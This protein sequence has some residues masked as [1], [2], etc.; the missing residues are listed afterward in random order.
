MVADIGLPDLETRQAILKR[1][2]ISQNK[3]VDDKI[4][5]FIA[6]NIQSSIRELEGALTK[7]IAT[8]ELTHLEITL[9]NAEN[10]LKGI[11]EKKKQT[12]TPEFIIREIAKYYSISIED[13]LGKKRTKEI[14]LSRQIT[15]YFL[16][17]ETGMSFPDIGKK[18]GG[19]DLPV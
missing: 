17:H 9:E 6:T 8:C 14:V 5:E 13:I 3:E 2:A 10:I 4:I 7:I 16:R 11:I 19:K 18:I 1:K 12:I 15:M